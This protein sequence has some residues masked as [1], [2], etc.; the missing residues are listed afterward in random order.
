MNLKGTPGERF[1]TV[2]VDVENKHIIDILEDRKVDTIKK[3]LRSRDTGQVKIVFMDMSK[4]FK[5]AVC[6]VLDHPLIIADRFHFM[7]QVYWLW[8]K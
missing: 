1:Q 3:Y 5:K 7:R 8:M 2:I 6:D 4:W